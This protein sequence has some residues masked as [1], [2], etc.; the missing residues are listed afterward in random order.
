MSHLKYDIVASINL[1]TAITEFIDVAKF[2]N[3]ARSI[4]HLNL[5]T[6]AQS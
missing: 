5:I 6:G 3:I 2:I 4:M 1:G